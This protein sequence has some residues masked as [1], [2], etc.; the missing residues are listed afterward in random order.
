PPDW[1]T[2]KE[3]FEP[4][5][6]PPWVPVKASKSKA[7]VLLREYEFNSVAVPSQVQTL[8]HDILAGP[9]EFRTTKPWDK[10][11]LKL[12]KKDDEAAVYDSESV[13]GGLT[14]QVRTQLEF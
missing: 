1:W 10:S 2:M 14:L 7:N 8:G 9:M 3:G 11:T 12:V 5:I 6:P 4:R 13:A